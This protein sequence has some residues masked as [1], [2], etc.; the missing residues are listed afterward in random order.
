M[1]TKV[2]Y[3]QHSIDHLLAPNSLKW[4]FYDGP[5]YGHISTPYHVCD[6]QSTFILRSNLFNLPLF[7]LS[8]ETSVVLVLSSTDSWLGKKL[9]K[10]PATCCV[11]SKDSLADSS[12]PI[13]SLNWSWSLLNSPAVAINR[14][15]WILHS[16]QSVT[17][18]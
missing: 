17:K 6:L 3:I 11:M 18:F 14:N 9:A 8:S 4:S 12:F 15:L 2:V 5:K 7:W 10:L 1:H 16:C 13:S